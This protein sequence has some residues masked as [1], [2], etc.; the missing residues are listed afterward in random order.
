MFCYCWFLRWQ[1]ATLMLYSSCIHGTLP[2]KRSRSVYPLVCD[3]S[4][5]VKTLMTK[6]LPIEDRQLYSVNSQETL[7]L[8]T[9]CSVFKPLVTFHL[10]AFATTN[11]T[12]QAIHLLASIISLWHEAWQTC[13]QFYHC[14][15]CWR[16]RMN[17]RKEPYKFRVLPANSL[18]SLRFNI[19][20]HTHTHTHTHTQLQYDFYKK[21]S[22]HFLTANKRMQDNHNTPYWKTEINEKTPR[23]LLTRVNSCPVV[24]SGI[25]LHR[26]MHFV[27]FIETEGRILFSET[28]Q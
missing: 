23:C 24:V 18:E 3:Q 27:V 8:C 19:Q 12:S 1:A 20:N 17:V 13:T 22:S 4:C 26:W 11:H 21:C 9:S 2:V 10:C 25:A 15:Q 16:L 6:R 28:V 14:D 7:W 5:S